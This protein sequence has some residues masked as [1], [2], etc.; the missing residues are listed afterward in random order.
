PDE[1]A[2]PRASGPARLA[3]QAH[4]PERAHD[5]SGLLSH[6][7]HAAQMA[8]TVSS[9]HSVA[10]ATG[11]RALH[12]ASGKQGTHRERFALLGDAGGSPERAGEPR[13]AI[14]PRRLGQALACGR[15]HAGVHDHARRPSSWSD[16]HA[17]A[18]AGLPAASQGEGGH[19]VLGETL[20]GLWLSAHATL[21]FRRALN[22]DHRLGGQHHIAIYIGGFYSVGKAMRL[23]SSAY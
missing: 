19:V 13:A 7:Q 11:S 23:T 4:R 6:A 3:S 9:A 17:G 12:A 21:G 14:S 5:S 16:L 22:L 20:E 2:H 1:P 18:S 8:E 15:V 10:G